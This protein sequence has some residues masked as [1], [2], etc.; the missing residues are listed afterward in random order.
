MKIK[1][2]INP[3]SKEF[4]DAFK[5][6]EESFPVFERR[7]LASQ[8]ELLENEKFNFN[9][10]LDDNKNVLALLLTW[11]NDEFFYIEHFAV[12][13]SARG[14]NIGTN[15]LT[16]LIEKTKKPIILEIE[17]PIDEI[18]I[19]RKKFYEKLGFVMNEFKHMHP[20]FIKGYEPYE[21][22]IVSLP[23]I[24]NDLFNIYENFIN[25]EVVPYS[26]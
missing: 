5:I 3:N 13:E 17:P 24:S 6:Y 9:I 20:V 25:N 16:Q 2:I 19:K 4:K 22:K 23:K 18:S 8:I 21:L 1:R 12:L 11:E 26:E 10:V 15:I 7:L 14:K